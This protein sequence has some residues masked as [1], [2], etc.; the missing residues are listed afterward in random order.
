MRGVT[1]ALVLVAIGGGAGAVARGGD[2]RVVRAEFA[3]A[4][5]LVT[6]NDVRLD[7]AV[8]GRVRSIALTRRGT[9]LVTLALR[10]RAAA[11]RSDATA[12][13]RPGDLLGDTYVA[14]DPGAG[15]A[16]LRGTLGMARTTNAPRLD[17]LLATFD[18]GVRAALRTLIV[19]A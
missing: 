4:R 15:R 1:V 9:A 11:P 6:G 17:D 18:P 19:E 8:V 16:P 14:Y 13:I 7:G 5:G 2:E 10:P 3:S 12:A